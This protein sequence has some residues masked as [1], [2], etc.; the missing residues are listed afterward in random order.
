MVV[1]ALGHP[2]LT[3]ANLFCEVFGNLLAR[4]LG[5]ATPAPA[6]VNLSAEVLVQV[7]MNL[8]EFEMELQRSL[9]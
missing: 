3:E 5:I 2:E 1:K 9:L 4:E 7:I 6:L 8:P